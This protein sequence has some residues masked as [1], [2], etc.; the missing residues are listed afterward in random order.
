MK[1][2]P[3]MFLLLILS[4]GIALA[5]PDF[6][7]ALTPEEEAQF[8]DILEPIMRVYNF[9][10]YAATVIGVL[11]LVFAGISFIT[12]GGE[13]GKKERAKNM[14]VGVIVGLGIIWIAPVVVDYIFT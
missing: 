7:R 2:A 11:V 10:K 1:L 3:I 5:A 4:A 14:A 9:I 12:A 6:D 13:Q 8:D